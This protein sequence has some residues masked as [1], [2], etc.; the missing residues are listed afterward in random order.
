MIV[1]GAIVWAVSIA[2]AIGLLELVERRRARRADL[3]SL[4][5]HERAR[6]VLR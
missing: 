3:A 2:A 6:E 4:R 5:R 1:V